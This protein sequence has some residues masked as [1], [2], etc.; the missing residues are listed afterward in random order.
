MKHENNLKRIQLIRN[1][2]KSKKPSQ[3]DFEQLKNNCSFNK[4]TLEQLYF[5]FPNHVQIRDEF[6][7]LMKSLPEF[8]FHPYQTDSKLSELRDINLRQAKVMVK[9]LSKT[10][11]MRQL[12]E[13]Q[14]K[15]AILSECISNY[16]FSLGVRYSVHMVLYYNSIKFLGTEMHRP[17]MDRCVTFEDHGCFGLTEL[18]HG[19]DVREIKL[20]ATYDPKTKEFVLHSDGYDSYKWW[21][22]GAGK[23]ANITVLF[24]QLYTKGECYG[25]HAFVVPLRNKRDNSPFPGVILGDIGPKVGIDGIDNG[26]IGFHNY[27]IPKDN[28]LNKFSNV[29]D[30][31][32]YS[33]TTKDADTRFAMTLG[34]LEE[35][36][37]GVSGGAQILLVNCIT[38]AGRYSFYRKQ[39]RTDSKSEE[40]AIINYQT[41]QLKVVPAL[42][43][44][45]ALRFACFVLA[46]KWFK[47]I[48]SII[49]FIF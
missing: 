33:S 17:Y 35:G 15:Y 7:N 48:V 1:Q 29:S 38:I 47:I 43:E 32:D 26:Y 45:L 11:D 4:K 39:F 25:V 31:G 37:V 28:L 40:N 34:A 41:V 30:D 18:G 20:K 5:P 13:D 36:R 8:S 44:A 12:R 9:E 3:V 19:S 14:S 27:R 21:I 49:I 10:Y 16:D 46:R 2:L 22:G 24:A 23:F 42:A 6:Y